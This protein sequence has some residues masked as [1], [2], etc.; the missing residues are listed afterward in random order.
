MN[1][2]RDL[3]KA[4]RDPAM[5]ANLVVAEKLFPVDTLDA[6]CASTGSIEEVRRVDHWPLVGR[7]DGPGR[8]A[9]ARDRTYLRAPGRVVGDTIGSTRVTGGRRPI[10]WIKAEARG[11]IQIVPIDDVQYFEA[12]CKYTR[13]VRATKCEVLIRM[14]I[15]NL[16]EG[17]DPL[18][19]LQIN[20][21]VIVNLAYVEE[22]VKQASHL[23]VVLRDSDRRI[24]VSEHYRNWFRSM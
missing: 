9:M 19:F 18:C 17:L 7:D 21:S 1:P 16:L 6:D 24:R 13:V 2:V 14:P 22:A 4:V 12:S 20:R 10:R 15:R 8:V 11:R 3:E 23:W 5:V